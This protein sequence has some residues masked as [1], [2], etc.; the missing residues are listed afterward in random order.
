MLRAGAAPPALVEPARRI[1]GRLR[2]PGDKSISHRHAIVAAL[3]RG[4]SHIEGFAPGA[5]CAATLDCL[6]ALGVR[7]ARTP[8]GAVDIEGRGLAGL[9]PPAAPLDARNSGTTMR[10]L[11]GVLA[12]H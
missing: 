10:L 8:A 11:V 12:A 2:P 7:V 5:D 4:A 3:A 6:V 1:R 9:L